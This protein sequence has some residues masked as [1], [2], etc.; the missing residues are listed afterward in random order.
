[1][2]PVFLI[3]TGVSSLVLVVMVIGLVRH[4][5]GLGRSLASF[6]REI[7]PVMA[8]IR[9]DAETARLRMERAA[10]AAETLRPS[11]PRPPR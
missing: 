8:D 2:V 7:E 11:D 3:I 5:S 6:Q 1:M 10:E 4:V 9:Q